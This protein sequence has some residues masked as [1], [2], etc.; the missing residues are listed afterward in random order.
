ML[1]KSKCRFKEE[2]RELVVTSL[3]KKEHTSESTVTRAHSK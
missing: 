3:R 2:E 1:A